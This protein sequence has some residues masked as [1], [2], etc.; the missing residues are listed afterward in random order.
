MRSQADL[1]SIHRLSTGNREVLGNSTR[2]GCFYCGALFDP[3]EV[4]DWI[5]GRQIDTGDTA[6]GVTALCPR[7]GIDSVLPEASGVTLSPELLGE[8][9]RY[10]F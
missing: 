3:R 6:D 9:H 4:T 2:A 1:E 10:W 5:D 7:C 8:M